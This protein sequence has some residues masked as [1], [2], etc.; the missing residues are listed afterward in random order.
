MIVSHQSL[1]RERR[2]RDQSDRQLTSSR[3][4][5]KW[6]ASR[7]P[8]PGAPLRGASS[9]LRPEDG[10]LSEADLSGHWRAPLWPPRGRPKGL[11]KGRRALSGQARDT[12]LQRSNPIPSHPIRSH[13]TPSHPIQS[14]PVGRHSGAH[15]ARRRLAPNERRTCRPWDRIRIRMAEYESA[16]VRRTEDNSHY[17]TR[18]RAGS[19][20]SRSSG[21]LDPGRVGWRRR[22]GEVSGVRAARRG[23]VE[24]IDGC[25]W[26]RAAGGRAREPAGRRLTGLDNLLL[27]IGA[28][29]PTGSRRPPRP[30]GRR[31]HLF[32]SRPADGKCV[33]DAG[34]RASPRVSSSRVSGSAS[35]LDTSS[36]IDVSSSKSIANDRKVL[37]IDQVDSFSSSRPR[38][39]V[40]CASQ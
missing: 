32:G 26:S 22:S 40:G 23:P 25:R 30:A 4:A 21:Q 5:S 2:L 15:P 37:T 3:P 17:L 19:S 7:P 33:P 12:A 29:L 13:P 9:I 8:L 16:S 20:P 24:K 11:S 14:D 28:P 31:A 39:S 35:A 27:S 6:P 38:A 1:A 18:S 34:R 36:R 10:P